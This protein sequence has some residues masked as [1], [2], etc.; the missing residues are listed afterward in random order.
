MSL[1]CSFGFL[2]MINCKDIYLDF[3]HSSPAGFLSDTLKYWLMLTAALPECICRSRTVML[4]SIM[5]RHTTLGK[6]LSVSSSLNTKRSSPLAREHFRW[7]FI[8]Q[9]RL[10]GCCMDNSTMY[11]RLVCSGSTP[12]NYLEGGFV[13]L[14][15]S[16][17]TG[18]TASSNYGT[19]H[20]SWIK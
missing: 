10:T 6:K 7:V 15:S 9:T 2:T 18:S 14:N 16:K 1:A 12:K 5:G 13:S 20:S 4:K 8:K 19:R 17:R 3:M 11:S